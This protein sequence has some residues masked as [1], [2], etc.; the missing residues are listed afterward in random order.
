MSAQVLVE[1]S[2]EKSVQLDQFPGLLTISKITP[3]RTETNVRVAQVC[4]SMQ[5][6]D[7]HQMVKSIR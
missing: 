5:G 2:N 6:K 1:E 3:K 7:M 4:G